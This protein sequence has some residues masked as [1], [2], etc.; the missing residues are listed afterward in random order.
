MHI[1]IAYQTDVFYDSEPFTYYF[2]TGKG[3]LGSTKA[4]G[5]IDSEK[6]S[7]ISEFLQD[8]QEL[9]IGEPA[10][11]PL[12]PTTTTTTTTPEIGTEQ[13]YVGNPDSSSTLSGMDKAM[14]KEPSGLTAVE[15]RLASEWAPLGLHFGIPLFDEE[16]N[17]IVCE[18][19][20]LGEDSILYKQGL[21]DA[22]KCPCTFK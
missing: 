18:K 5:A 12:L 13:S 22:L 19:V 8:M 17:K 4:A 1:P 21:H 10:P 16:A 6:Q 11:P 2:I 9:G 14:E 3:A 20:N 15:R 7:K